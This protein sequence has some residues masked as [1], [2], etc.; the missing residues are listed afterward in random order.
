VLWSPLVALVVLRRAPRSIV[1]LIV[2]P[3]ILT[4][5]IYVFR[6]TLRPL[7][8]VGPNSTVLNTSR[9]DQIFKQ[10]AGVQ[11]AYV[12]ATDFL[13]GR[14]CSEVGIDTGLEYPVWV[15]LQRSPHRP[16]LRIEHAFVTNLSAARS[17]AEPFAG[18]SPCAVLVDSN[19]GPPCSPREADKEA[20]FQGRPFTKAWSSGKVAVFV[21]RDPSG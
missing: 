15:L 10:F 13:A 5:T 9:V 2:V 8:G 20:L 1:L 16:P 7:V 12:G 19:C 4:S 17:A 6:N 14:R 3:L 18:R 11:D 21:K